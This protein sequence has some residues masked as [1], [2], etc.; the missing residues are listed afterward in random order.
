M[1]FILEHWQLILGIAAIM[2]LYIRFWLL[3]IMRKNDVKNVYQH[4]ARPC[5]ILQI[6]GEDKEF[7]ARVEREQLRYL[8]SKNRW[9]LV[10]PPVIY[11]PYH[12]AFEFE[13]FGQKYHRSTTN[14]SYDEYLFAGIAFYHEMVEIWDKQ[15]YGKHGMQNMMQMTRNQKP[16]DGDRLWQSIKHKS[17]QS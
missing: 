8:D 9:A 4:A 1:H 10:Q 2:G 6:N 13:W 3:P 11:F 16:V 15:V 17:T 14:M 7:W 5:L 12:C